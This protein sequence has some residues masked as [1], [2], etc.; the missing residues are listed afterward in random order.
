MS[1]CI[2]DVVLLTPAALNACWFLT[3]SAAARDDVRSF[4]ITRIAL[5]DSGRILY[6]CMYLGNA[7]TNNR[8]LYP[9]TIQ[10]LP[11]ESTSALSGLMRHLLLF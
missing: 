9:C 7:V 6:L 3:H 1:K 11:I 2:S 10:Y 5:Y 4:F 8:H